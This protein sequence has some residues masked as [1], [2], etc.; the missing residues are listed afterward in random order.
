MAIDQIETFGESLIQHGPANN[1]VYLMKL[2]R[3]DFPQI[4]GFI[5]GLALLHGYSKVFAKVPAYARAGFEQE[6]YQVEAAIPGFY[7]GRKD[8]LFMSRYFHPDR[9]IDHAADRV[10]EVLQTAMEKK[11][12][13][14]EAQPQSDIEQRLAIP[15]D[16]AQMA[17]LYRKVFASYPFPIHDP[18]YLAGTMAENVIYAGSWENGQLL[19]LA[20]AEVDP[21]GGN[22]EMTD[23][24]TTPECRGRGLANQLLGKLESL[25]A[26][27]DIQTCYTIARAT[28]FGMNITFAKNGYE[29]GGTLIKNTQISGTLESMNVWHKKL[30]S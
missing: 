2:K 16:S 22:A 15:S 12:N 27:A 7:N 14:P 5:N 11:S 26:Q 19:A 10:H 3:E 13:E 18:A 4:I 9:L 28:S 23:F 8:G 20:S 1:R 30:S 6:G 21:E 24:A 29:F 17:E 25:M